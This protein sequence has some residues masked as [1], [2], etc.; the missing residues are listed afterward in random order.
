MNASNVLKKGVIASLMVAMCMTASAAES[1]SFC[2]AH[3]PKADTVVVVK[4]RPHV[5]HRHR[6]DKKVVKEVVIIKR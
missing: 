6:H 4:K 1:V 5:K 2:S 3:S